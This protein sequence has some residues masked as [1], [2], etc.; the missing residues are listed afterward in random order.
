VNPVEGYHYHA[1][2]GC[3]EKEPPINGHSGL[4]AY[5]LDGYSCYGMLGVDANE[6]TDLQFVA[7]IM[8]TIA[9]TTTT[10]PAPPRTCSSA[11][12]PANKAAFNDCPQAFHCSVITS[13][14]GCNPGSRSRGPH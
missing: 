11:V 3:A 9:A 1:S 8:K 12:L 4:M 5:A 6:P 13:S 14:P 7:A 2:V 10:R